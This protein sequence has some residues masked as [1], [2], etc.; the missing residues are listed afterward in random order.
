MRRTSWADRLRYALD[1]TLARGPAAMIA[2][3]ALASAAVILLISLI[4]WAAGAAPGLGFH[5]TPKHASWLNMA[6]IELSAFT[7]QCLGQRMG[8]EETLVHQARALEQEQPQAGEGRLAVQNRG[9]PYQTQSPL[10]IDI[11]MTEHG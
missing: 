4:A 6:E 10:S 9:C 11:T 7:R 2:W 8:E 5:Y 3:L 1:N